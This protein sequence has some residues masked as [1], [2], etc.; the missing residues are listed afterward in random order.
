MPAY[1]TRKARLLDNIIEGI[2]RL[3][4]RGVY[5]IKCGDYGHVY[6][7]QTGRSLKLEARDI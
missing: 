6:I 1:Y 5:K 2:D 4:K 3:D 7:G